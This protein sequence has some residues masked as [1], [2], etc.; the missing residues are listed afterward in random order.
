MALGC[1]MPVRRATV[2]T[3]GLLRRRNN[4]FLSENLPSE[5][6]A[7]S[8]LQQFPKLHLGPPAPPTPL[9]LCQQLSSHLPAGQERSAPREASQVAETVFHTSL[10]RSAC[11]VL[12]QSCPQPSW[13]PPQ[14][15]HGWGHRGS[16]AAPS[17]VQSPPQQLL[18]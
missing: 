12:S 7:Q 1:E 3:P 18:P 10:S 4:F 15:P 16:T 11:P 8:W 13:S 14:L 9:F 17:Q 2:D 6:S 5:F